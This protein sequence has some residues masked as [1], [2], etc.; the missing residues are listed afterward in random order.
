MQKEN[1]VLCQSNS[2]EE[3]CRSFR[4]VTSFCS[5]REFRGSHDSFVNLHSSFSTLRPSSWSNTPGCNKEIHGTIEIFVT[6]RILF[7]LIHFT[8]QLQTQNLSQRR[9]TCCLSSG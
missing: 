9:Y 4:R 1:I 7:V 3:A 8:H 5:F 6:E 2:T